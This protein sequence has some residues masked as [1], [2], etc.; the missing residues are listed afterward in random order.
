MGHYGFM[1]LPP[2][3]CLAQPPSA[4][5]PPGGVGGG[6]SDHQRRRALPKKHSRKKK[7]KKKSI[8]GELAAY[9]SSSLPEYLHLFSG[10]WESK[11]G[12]IL[13][14]AQVPRYKCFP[15]GLET[16]LHPSQNVEDVSRHR[17]SSSPNVPAA[18]I[19]RAWH[20][21]GAQ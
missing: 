5:L 8:P 14:S 4:L 6:G 15:T 17:L 18:V 3:L 7:K 19:Q 13:D 1:D 21:A 2:L 20:K 11:P 16:K 10:A 12:E 9:Q